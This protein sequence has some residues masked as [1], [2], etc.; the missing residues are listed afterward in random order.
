MQEVN[1]G[2][3]FVSMGNL[4]GELKSYI[5]MP[6]DSFDIVFQSLNLKIM[7]AAAKGE[8]SFTDLLKSSGIPRGQ[9]ARHLKALIKANWLIHRGK[10]YE[11]AAALFVAFNADYSDG[12]IKLRLRNDRGAFMDPQ[13]GILIF[14]GSTGLCKTCPFREACVK[15]VKNLSKAYDIVIRS[16][17]PSDAYV[18]IFNALISRDLIKRLKTQSLIPATGAIRSS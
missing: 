4:K 14:K 1:A 10:C 17:E 12:E 2:N 5:L 7:E 6:V 11:P 15:N 18:E 3:V 8:C 9:L 13:Y 16:V